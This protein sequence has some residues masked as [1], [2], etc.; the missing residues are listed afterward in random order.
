MKA[1][2]TNFS[3]LI[4]RSWRAD[5]ESQVNIPT[6]EYIRQETIINVSIILYI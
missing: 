2:M 3:I 6:E 1:P 5:R 4:L